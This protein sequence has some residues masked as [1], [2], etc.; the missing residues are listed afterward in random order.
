MPQVSLLQRIVRPGVVLAALV[1]AGLA[2]NSQVNENQALREQD[3]NLKE[4]LDEKETERSQQIA[5]QQ[6]A[7]AKLIQ[8]SNRKSSE[9]D[10]RLTILTQ[11]QEDERNERDDLVGRLAQTEDENLSLKDKLENEKARN[12]E[13]TTALDNLTKVVS[14]KEDKDE[15]V[16]AIQKVEPSTV[17]IESDSAKWAGSI[18]KINGKLFLS[19]AAHPY[20]DVGDFVLT[21]IK[22]KGPN[23]SFKI[24]PPPFNGNKVAFFSFAEESDLALIPLPDDIVKTL[25]PGIGLPLRNLAKDPLRKGEE[26]LTI[27]NPIGL[28]HTATLRTI[29]GLGRFFDLTNGDNITKGQHLAEYIQLE[30]AL[31][32]GNSGSS[33]VD[34]EGRVIAISSFTNRQGIMPTG[35]AI[36]NL[37]ETLQGRCGMDVMSDDEKLAWEIK[38]I[39]NLRNPANIPLVLA[40]IIPD[41]ERIPELPDYNDVRTRALAQRAEQV[42]QR[43]QFFVSLFGALRKLPEF[44]PPIPDDGLPSIE[45]PPAPEDFSE[46]TPLVP[47]PDP[48]FSGPDKSKEVA[49][50]PAEESDEKIIKL[51]E[52]APAPK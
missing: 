9:F 50:P 37:K 33:V 52:N 41:E 27:G 21:E 18:W 25:P 11:A 38:R 35:F 47:M 8:E 28:E 29:S 51:E 26:V 5:A 10:G 44:K 1:A 45:V 24:T 36:T 12:E 32:V 31:N 48:L 39:S 43:L 30:P 16:K 4:T 42:R 46:D 22:V 23:Y 7:I 49:P 15:L 34:L 14:S 2:V 20:T 40:G 3:T 17:M 19:T 13:L 6:S